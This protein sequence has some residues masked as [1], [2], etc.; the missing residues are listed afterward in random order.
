MLTKKIPPEGDG[1]SVTPLIPILKQ[2][3]LPTRKIYISDGY[4]EF[5]LSLHG[6]PVSA[7]ERFFNN[8]IVANEDYLES[9]FPVWNKKHV[10]T[11]RS[12]HFHLS[13]YVTKNNKFIVNGQSYKSRIGE[14][15]GHWNPNSA[16]TKSI[17]AKNF[18]SSVADKKYFDK[19]ELT[20]IFTLY[21]SKDFIS[22]PFHCSHP[23]Y[24]HY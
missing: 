22:H 4:T 1:R 7:G 9:T 8:G 2:Q 5:F 23:S 16:N 14:I 17:Y 15:S 10:K 3:P 24:G 21:I 19:E 13:S 20:P 6:I 11:L 12:L 18:L